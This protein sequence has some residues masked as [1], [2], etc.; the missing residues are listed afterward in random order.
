M[1]EQ[2]LEIKELVRFVVNVKNGF[3][4]GAVKSGLEKLAA[5]LN[6]KGLE[7]T[8][9]SPLSLSGQTNQ[10]TYEMLFG[11]RLDYAEQIVQN[12]NRG[13]N[14]GYSVKEWC[15][16]HPARVPWEFDCVINSIELQQ[17]IYLTD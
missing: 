11:A 12:L 8:E 10:E 15:E 2:E 16:L 4:P 14:A 7:L 9:S 17:K 5:S 6:F 1:E 13:P 3:N